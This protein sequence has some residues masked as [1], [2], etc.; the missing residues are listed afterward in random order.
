M[1]LLESGDKYVC[2]LP[3]LS[4][5]PLPQSAPA[6]R[7]VVVVRRGIAISV[8]DAAEASHGYEVEKRCA[9]EVVSTEVGLIIP[10]ENESELPSKIFLSTTEVSAKRI[11]IC[12]ANISVGVIYYHM[13]S[14]P[15]CYSGPEV[16]GGA[17][18]F[19]GMCIPFMLSPNSTSDMTLLQESTRPNATGG[20]FSPPGTC[21]CNDGWSGLTDYVPL[22]LS[23]WGG[24][25]QLCGVHVL[26]VK[27]LWSFVLIPTTMI[28]LLWRPGVREQWKVFK[29]NR[30]A[31][32]WWEHFP[33][34]VFNVALPLE[35]GSAIGLVLCKIIPER[36][37]LIGVHFL[38]TLF[39]AIGSFS[40]V[41]RTLRLLHPR[42]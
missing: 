6:G 35:T 38:P 40:Q 20:A 34:I 19:S 16:I 5:L 37:L 17:T 3:S 27:I 14:S 7:L 24:P 41:G 12:F 1:P 42:A 30:R 4:L 18:C 26:T 36:P 32:R 15:L 13:A 28:L 25:V 2:G 11:A 39:M 10:S 31:R 21:L 33:L 23:D 8:A 22:D 9:R 29:G